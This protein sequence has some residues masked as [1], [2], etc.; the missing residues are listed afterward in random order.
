MQYT[1]RP[2]GARNQYLRYDYVLKEAVDIL[3]SSLEGGKNN[4]REFNKLFINLISKL[5]KYA[6]KRTVYIK[7]GVSYV[8]TAI[9][10]ETGLI[11]FSTKETKEGKVFDIEMFNEPS[12]KYIIN[13]KKGE[14]VV[15]QKNMSRYPNNFIALKELMFKNTREQLLK[16]GKILGTYVSPNEYV[17]L[18]DAKGKDLTDL[19]DLQLDSKVLGAG[20]YLTLEDLSLTLRIRDLDL[21]VKEGRALSLESEWALGDYFSKYIGITP[22]KFVYKVQDKDGR[23]FLVAF[24]G[25]ELLE[26]YY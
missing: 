26:I 15:E 22:Q 8:V 18:V 10:S 14:Y 13:Y 1:L 16:E 4:P 7:D 17:E 12:K 3:V 5:E 9:Q 23:Q 2:E 21:K 11:K 19:G 6:G 20:H 24:F 25:S